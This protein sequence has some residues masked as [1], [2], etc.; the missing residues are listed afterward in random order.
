MK[1]VVVVF[2]WL[3]FLL[4]LVL[5]LLM[6]LWLFV[7]KRMSLM[8]NDVPGFVVF[9]LRSEVSVKILML[10]SL[11]LLLLL[12]LL[13]FSLLLL[14]LLSLLLFSLLL[15]LLLLLSLL[16]FSLLLLL[17][18]LSLLLLLL[19]CSCFC[20]FLYL[21]SLLIFSFFV[22][23]LVFASHW[24]PPSLESSLL[25]RG[26]VSLWWSLLRLL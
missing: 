17:L 13:L 3:A 9:M 10:F 14:L 20:F 25:S 8:K 12:S 24:S 18:F 11:L 6:L 15:L 21:D 5:L 1:G 26:F 2:E 7:L 4:L 22:V 23:S 16:L 19:S